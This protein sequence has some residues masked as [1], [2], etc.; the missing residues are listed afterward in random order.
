MGFGFSSK[1]FPAQTTDFHQKFKLIIL[2]LKMF[3]RLR[4]DIIIHIN[5]INDIDFF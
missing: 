4:V 2:S 1:R 3:W 5:Q